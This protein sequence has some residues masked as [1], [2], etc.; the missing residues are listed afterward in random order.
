MPLLIG[1]P[2]I[3]AGI[4]VADAVTL[5]DVAPT[6]MRALGA[7]MT[8]VDGIDLSPAFSRASTAAARALCRVVRAAGR[9]RLGAAARRALG[10]MEAD[11]VAE[12]GAVQHETDP[13]ERSNAIASQPDVARRL[14]ARADSYS[15]D[16]LSA[17]AGV[18]G[19][20][21]AERLRALG[22][23]SGSA[24]GSQSSALSHVPIRRI[25]E[26]WLRGSLR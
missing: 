8:A 17:S 22:Y 4:R 19:G 24:L 2:G 25:G 10:G 3:P 6:V 18:P 23:S 13:A 9:I 15:S 7:P 12:A 16:S 1:G 20:E 11:C 5:A 14:T 21:A 26:S